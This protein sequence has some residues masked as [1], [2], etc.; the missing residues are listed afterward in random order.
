MNKLCLERVALDLDAQKITPA[1]NRC[2]AL[3]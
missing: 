1:I 3:V 2:T